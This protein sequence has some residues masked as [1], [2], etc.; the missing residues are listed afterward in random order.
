M[1]ISGWRQLCI[2]RHNQQFFTNEAALGPGRQIIDNR[3][4]RL[5]PIFNNVVA[6]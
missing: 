2:R 5:G 1:D 4:I 3:L 6:F